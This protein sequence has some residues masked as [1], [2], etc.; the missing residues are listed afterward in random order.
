MTIVEY[1]EEVYGL[2][3]LDYQKEVISKAEKAG[4]PYVN[5]PPNMGRV[6][7]ANLLTIKNLI[8]KGEF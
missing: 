6:A 2:E 3:L 4:D 5:F 1:I 7:A 8:L